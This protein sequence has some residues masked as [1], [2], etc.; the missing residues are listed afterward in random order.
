MPL[1]FLF[2]PLIAFAVFAGLLI[3]PGRYV[4]LPYMFDD[5][6][7][8]QELVHRTRPGLDARLQAFAEEVARRRKQGGYDEIVFMGHSLGC[9]LKLDVVDRALRIEGGLRARE[10]AVQHAV[11]GLVAA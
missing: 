11:G 3:F 6:I 10:R 1:P 7:F 2:A 4:M 9:A 5:W 8:A